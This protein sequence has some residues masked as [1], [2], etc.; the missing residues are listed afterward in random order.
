MNAYTLEVSAC[1]G[2]ARIEQVLL[3]QEAHEVRV[4][5][6]EIVRTFG[7]GRDEPEDTPDSEQE[8]G[9]NDGGEDS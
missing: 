3:A 5:A 4:Y 7:G 2:A 8:V 9:A 1:G 6:A